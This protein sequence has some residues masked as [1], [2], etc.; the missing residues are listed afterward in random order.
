MLHDF[1]E[2]SELKKRFAEAGSSV[3]MGGPD[4]RDDRVLLPRHPAL[5]EDHPESGSGHAIGLVPDYVY[6]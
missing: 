3:L 2:S 5:A 1:D 6:P 4:R